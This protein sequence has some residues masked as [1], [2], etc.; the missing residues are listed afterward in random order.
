MSANPVVCSHLVKRFGEQVVVQDL[1]FTVPA[2]SILALLGPSG[3]GK[4]TTLRLIA[5]LE[6]VEQGQIEI[7]G[8]VVANGRV[9]IPIE[10]REIGIV[11]QDYAIFPHLSVAQNVGFGLPRGSQERIAEMLAFVG[12]QGLGER[13][14]QELSG[15]QQQRVALARAIARRPAV[16]LLDEPFSNLDAALRVEMRHEI[17]QLLKKAQMTAIFVTHD[18]EEALFMGDKVAVMNKGHIEQLGTPEEIF[19]QPQ[20]LFVADFIGQTDFLPGRVTVS[21]IE[22]PLGLLNQQIDAPAGA[23]VQIALRADDVALMPHPQGNGRVL[24]RQFIGIAY[25]YTIA[26]TDGSQVHSWQPH[27]VSLAEGTAVQASFVHDHPL[28]CFVNGRAV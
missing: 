16:L 19:H 6:K 4:T 7:G 15:G 17:R 24:S 2:G 10:K 22:T 11:F 12:L 5:G 3:C 27:R 21:G 23:E 13:M 9:H 1:T 8:Q 28:T 18:Q 25:I 20:T 14:P 26:L